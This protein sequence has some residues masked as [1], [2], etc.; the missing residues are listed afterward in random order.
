MY[1]GLY[2]HIPFCTHR[3][4]YCDFNTYD[5]REELIAEYSHALMTEIRRHKG[6]A[7]KGGLKSLY[8]GGGTPSLLSSAEVKALITEARGSLGFRDDVEIT[9]EVNPGTASR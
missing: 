6:H 5:D 3:C 1:H 9:L 2:L 4:G 7:I 8:F